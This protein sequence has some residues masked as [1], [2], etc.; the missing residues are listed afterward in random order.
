MNNLD[1]E[2]VIGISALLVHAA[3]IDEIYSDHEKELILDFIKSYLTDENA[4][5]ILKKA[6]DIE[7]NSNQLLNY[8][9]IIKKNSMSTKKDIIEHLWKVI[10]SDN[11]VDQY[12]ANLMRRVC[13]LIY[14]P[15][16]EC[17]EIK[18]KLLNSK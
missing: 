17:A 7:K 4:N 8:T 3:H 15:D 6:E 10:I 13:G 16:K 2:S 14:F 1:K 18:L 11:S 9:N 12:E 5:E